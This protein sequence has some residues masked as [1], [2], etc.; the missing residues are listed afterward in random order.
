M[1]QGVGKIE[2]FFHKKSNVV[3]VFSKSELLTCTCTWTL[4]VLVA[5][6]KKNPDFPEGRGRMFGTRKVIFKVQLLILTPGRRRSRG[7]KDLLRQNEIVWIFCGRACC[8][9]FWLSPGVWPSPGQRCYGPGCKPIFFPLLSGDSWPE[10]GK[11]RRF[12][13]LEVRNRHKM[14]SRCQFTIMA[15]ARPVK[16]G[17]AQRRRFRVFRA[18]KI[19]VVPARSR[20]T[21][22]VQCYIK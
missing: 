9:G 20:P 12:L 16:R 7:A 18:S 11:M 22:D 21:F 17:V 2:F 10:S 15:L 14:G 4:C 8:S 6:A 3:V 1:T 5:V 13:A 19:L